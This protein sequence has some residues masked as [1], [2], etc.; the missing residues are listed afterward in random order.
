MKL[1]KTI[2]FILFTSI[3]YKTSAQVATPT[4]S[5][6]NDSGFQFS[7]RGGYDLYPM[8]DNN[9]PYIDYKGGI[10]VGAS[11][12]Y[13]WGWFGMGLDFDYIKNSTKNSY[14]TTDLLF[15]GAP[16][17]GINYS[18]ET[19]KRTFFGIG[20]NFKYQKNNK[21]STELKFRAGLANIKG[22][23]LQMDGV[24]SSL[25]PVLLNYHAGYDAKNVFSGKASLQFN[26]FFNNTFGIHAGAY[27]MRHFGVD[28]LVDATT[29]YSSAYAPFT[30]STSLTSVPNNNVTTLVPASREDCNCDIS[31]VGVFAGITIKINSDKDD[32][33]MNCPNFSLAVTAKD[34]FTKELIPNT[35]VALKNKKGE[36]IQTG[37]TNNFGVVVFN[38]ILPD[39]YVVEGKLYDISLDKSTTLKSEFKSNETLQKEIQYSDMN[40]ILKGK[41]V[42]C[43][44]TKPINGVSVVLK[45]TSLGEQKSTMTDA[46]GEYIFN[47]KQQAE[48]TLYGKK[49]N[50][51]SQIETISTKEFNRNSTLFIKLEVCMDEVDC[52]KSL[53][54]KNI[55]YDLNK[56]NINEQAKK[57]LNR[58]V[59]FMQDN[60]NTKVEISSHTDSRDTNTY[61]QTLSQNRAN[62]AVDYVIS[63]G[64]N[65]SRI[66]GVGYGETRLL[67]K[68]ADGVECTETQHQLNRRTEMKVICPN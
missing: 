3:V 16:I 35:D 49:E 48:Y 11:V 33:C 37:T 12:D 34:K 15:A 63:Q 20:P 64:I 38:N 5:S 9:T 55:F 29:G 31:S 41:A 10:D 13:Y 7:L 18:N 43:N 26:Y 45:N 23:K 59:Q 57:E 27:Y 62:A 42:I 21:F 66:I 19:I 32:K 8:Y 30:T 22:G 58:L 46:N 2:L 14:P 52:G 40:F 17:T 24:T 1:L 56:F 39:D 47:V 68:C 4:S 53:N 25:L 28:E 60:P 44:T 65:G 61:N 50:Y 36:I 67:N 54:L 51:F 6:I